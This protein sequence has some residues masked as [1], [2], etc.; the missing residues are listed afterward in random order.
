MCFEP[1][2]MSLL[3]TGISAAST[4]MG[5]VVGMMQANQQADIDRQNAILADENAEDALERSREEETR[6]R[7][8]SAALFGE[9]IARMAANG[10]DVGSGSPLKA[11][12]DTKVL[13][14][15]DAGRIRESGRRE[16]YTFSVEA[17]NLRSRARSRKRGAIFG[18]GK[19]L[20]TGASQF[21]RNAFGSSAFKTRG[22]TAT[23]AVN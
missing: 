4:M 1:A 18:L 5:G 21:G 19:S 11:L 9:Q 10:L 17:S 3:M 15:E 8:Q 12:G 22:R 2:S 14:E 16:A 20:I 6:H 13:E 23:K 7:R